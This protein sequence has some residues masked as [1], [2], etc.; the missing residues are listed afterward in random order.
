VQPNF[1]DQDAGARL[2]LQI[3]GN[4]DLKVATNLLEGGLELDLNVKGT[5]TVPRLFGTVEVR[6]GS[7][8]FFRGQVYSIRRGIVQMIDPSGRVPFL[9]IEAE[10]T[11]TYE[12]AR[13]ARREYRVILTML[14]PVD[15]LRIDFQSEPPLEEFQIL[16]LLSFGVLPEDMQSS[17]AGAT[18]G[19][20]ISNLVLSEQIS[21]IEREIQTLIGFDRLE[22]EPAFSGQQGGGSAM[23][24]TLQKQ[25]SDRFRLSLNSNLDTLGG[26]RVEIGYRL[27][28]GLD[29]SVGWDSPDEPGDRQIG[30]FFTR[31]RFVVPI[32]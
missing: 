2:D 3:R 9:D 23:Q 19:R 12:P 32:P 29:V 13:A 6:Q 31:P 11:V 22:I 7:L 18:A 8:F 15:R 30:S 21:R 16:T 26:Q 20:E 24:V 17:E 14:G 25:L 28:E 1:L 27:M 4:R 5:L 10:T